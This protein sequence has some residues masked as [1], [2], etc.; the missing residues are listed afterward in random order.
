MRVK[1]LPY[2]GRFVVMEAMLVMAVPVGLILHCK[3]SVCQPDHLPQ[4]IVKVEVV[5]T[6][7]VNLVLAPE[8]TIIA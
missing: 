1:W 4:M 3:L 2:K 6:R 8:L 7:H 5:Q